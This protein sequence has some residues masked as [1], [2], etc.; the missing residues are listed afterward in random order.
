MTPINYQLLDKMLQLNIGH[1]NKV[2]LTPEMQQG[3][4]ILSMSSEDVNEEI[5]SVLHNNVLLQTNTFKTG[6]SMNDGMNSQMSGDYFEKIKDEKSLKEHLREQLNLTS[7]PI[8]IRVSGLILIECVGEDGYL[9]EDESGLSPEDSDVPIGILQSFEPSGVAGRNLKEVLMIQSKEN[10]WKLETAIL[11]EGLE[12]IATKD[13]ERLSKNL[14]ISTGLVE[15]AIARIKTLNPKPGLSYSKPEI[16][17]APDAYISISASTTEIGI[18]DSIKSVSIINEAKALIKADSGLRESYNEAKALINGISHRQNTLRLV[19]GAIAEAQRD[20]FLNDEYSLKPMTMAEIADRCGVHES[21]VSRVS[22]SKYIETRYGLMKL[23]DF[24]CSSIK[25][26]DGE[27][28]SR[29]VKKMIKGIIS[30][31]IV[32]KPISD[33]GITTE[34]NGAGILISRRTV[35]K[36]RI[37][38][39]IPNSTNRVIK[40]K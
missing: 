6:S 16:M 35:A 4:K 32:T 28:S 2:C 9:N 38:M 36:Y 29:S 12:Y 33:M 37:Q 14:S 18:Y 19:L 13:Y 25:L 34:L 15:A 8:D 23:R 3:I 30:E 17:I 24:F 40:F 39:D 5:A 21:T 27:I 20:F 26:D 31:E 11:D 10:G 1:S 7:C 22:G